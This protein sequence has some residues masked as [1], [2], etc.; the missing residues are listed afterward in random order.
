MTPG[1]FRD[2][3][4]G[5]HFRAE[6]RSREIRHPPNWVPLVHELSVIGSNCVL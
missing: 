2:E 5:Q 1:E 3:F 4:H 6:N